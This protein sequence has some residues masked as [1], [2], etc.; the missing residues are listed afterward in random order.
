MVGV[1]VGIQRAKRGEGSHPYFPFC[2]ALSLFW[3]QSELHIWV[4]FTRDLLSSTAQPSALP[5]RQGQSWEEAEYAEDCNGG[6][7][8]C[9][10]GVVQGKLTSVYSCGAEV[11]IWNSV[12]GL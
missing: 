7:G 8:L 9:K 5:F 12:Y 3:P 11:F 2:T 4:L 6:C 10:I 1:G